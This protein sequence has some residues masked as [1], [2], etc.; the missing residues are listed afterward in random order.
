VNG[1]R[2]AQCVLHPGDVI[3]LAGVQLVFGQEASGSLDNTQEIV[4]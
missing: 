4:L 1:Q 3:S 2:V